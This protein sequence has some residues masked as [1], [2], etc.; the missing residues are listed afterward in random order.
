MAADITRRQ[1]FRLDLPR[2]FAGLQSGDRDRSVQAIRPPGA[3]KEECSFLETCERCH[4]CSDAC[5]FGVIRHLGP[6]AG[7]GEGTPFV[8]PNQ[9]PCRWCADMDCIRACPSGALTYDADG[10]VPALGTALLEKSTCLVSE[11]ILCDECVSVC[12]EDVAAARLVGREPHL[13]QTRCVGCGLCVLHC[14]ST[15]SSIRVI[16]V[17]DQRE[18]RRLQRP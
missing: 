8:A 12:P 9:N 14:P 10:N 18:G 6:A 2:I 17:G 4:K 5:P 11:G 15:P 1:F 3:L 7:T 16:P 13:D